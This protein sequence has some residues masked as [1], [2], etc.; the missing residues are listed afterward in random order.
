MPNIFIHTTFSVCFTFIF[1]SWLWYS[2]SSPFSSFLLWLM[3]SLA[4]WWFCLEICQKNFKIQC[5]K[6]M[7]NQTIF[8]NFWT[9]NFL[10]DLIISRYHQFLE[11][12][13]QNQNYFCNNLHEKQ[14]VQK[15]TFIIFRFWVFFLGLCSAAWISWS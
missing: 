8:W 15:L 7:C 9:Q 12:K 10:S 13:S 1:M 2:L 3:V 11:I 4:G 14:Q 5:Y 6:I